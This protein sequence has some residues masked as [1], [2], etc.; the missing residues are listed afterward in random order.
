[1]KLTFEDKIKIVR[2]Y[3][4]INPEPVMNIGHK[5]DGKNSYEDFSGKI[6]GLLIGRRT[7]F[8]N[9]IVN[10]FYRLTKD[11]LIDNQLVDNDAK[12]VDFSQTN[13]FSINQEI[14]NLFEIYPLQNNV[15]SLNGKRPIKFNIR[16]VSALDKDRTFNFNSINKRYSYVAD[17][18][19]LVYDFGI[20]SLG[21]IAMRAYTDVNENKQYLFEGKDES[22]NVFGLFRNSNKSLVIDVNGSKLTTN[23]LFETNKWQSVS[24]SFK[25]NISS[26]SQS[27]K[28]LD[29]RVTVDD[30]TWSTS[31]SVTFSYKKLDFMIGR[32]HKEVTIP[33]IFGSYKT[34]YPLYG[35]IEMIATRA[36]YC[37]ASTLSSLVNELKGLTKVSEFDEF[38]MLKKVD[39]HE[40]GNSILSNTYEYKKRSNNS[41]YISKQIKTEKIKVGSETYTRSYE[42]DALGNITKITDSTFGSHSYEYDSRGF[43][44]KADDETYSY[45][46]NGNIVKK[47]D[48]TLTYDS[49]IK[50]RLVSFNGTK[51]EYDS[52]NP[53]NPRKYGSNT[54]QFEGRR[55]VRW[56]Y[57]GGYYDYVYNDE[58]LRIKKTDYRGI[59]WN[60]IY[61]GNKLIR[62]K[63]INNTLDFLYDEY[64]NLY[65]FIKDNSEKYLYIRDQLQNIIGITDINGKIVVKYSYDAWGALKNIEDTSSSGIGK[66]NPFR[67]KG[68]YYDNESSMYY[69][70]TRYYVPQWGRWLSPDSIEYL[71]PESINKLNLYTYANNNPVIYYDPDGHMALLCAL[72][73]LGAIGM[74]A[75]VGSQALT[76]LAYRNEF[77]WENYLVAAG[78]GFLGGMCYAIPGVGSIVSAAVTSGLTTAGQMIVSGEYYDCWDYLIMAGGSAILS[79]LTAWEFGKISNNLSFFKD[80]NFILDN[81]S[82]FATNY[83]GITLKSTVILQA[84]GQ[85]AIRE[86]IA[87]FVGAPLSGIPGYFDRVYRLNKQGLSPVDSF[88]Y[89][90]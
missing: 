32:S 85:I 68:Y 62:E 48:Y 19:E 54:Y 39:I 65:G 26:S 36:A 60:Y 53:L 3:V 15:V 8:L 37:E 35:Q 18:E 20:S 71:N 66:L 88:L 21:T 67:F 59:T 33:M 50:D 30:K 55:L 5:Y 42:S 38:G 58:G 2:L 81:F 24:L 22:G 56:L 10:K 14:H 13:L 45:D 63:S 28:Y 41:K 78:A 12:I 57:G 1:M 76:D 74:V 9:D 77:K 47:G 64:D 89:A 84:A 75:N 46:K 4:D 6:T 23:L 34:S 25:E 80:S 17:G 40:C 31:E 83:G 69:C 7:Y 16:N 27:S 51:I 90:F 52:S 73:I 43:L 61:D 86:T 44:I 79:G 72:L 82:K 11:Y 70:K 87:G 49:N 29:I